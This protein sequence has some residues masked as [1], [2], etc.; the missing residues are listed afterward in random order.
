M[1]NTMFRKTAIAVAAAST[2]LTAAPAFA[3]GWGEPEVIVTEDG[4]IVD[5]RDTRHRPVIVEEDYG[6][7]ILSQRQII[8]ALRHQGYAQVREI[9]L[10]NE[11]YRVVAV[12][13]NGAVVKLRVSAIDGQVLSERRIGW[14]RSAPVRIYERP[15]PLYRHTEPGVSIQFGWSSN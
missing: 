11:T 2:L 10:R 13:H 7:D 15:A 6:Y 1:F 12:R 4:L 8:R 3:G 5:G 14:V 9:G